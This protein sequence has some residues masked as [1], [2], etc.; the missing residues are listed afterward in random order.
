MLCTHSVCYKSPVELR[1][2]LRHDNNVLNRILGLRYYSLNK[3]GFTLIELMIVILLISVIAG[4]TIPQF[5]NFNHRGQV[6]AGTRTLVELL[7]TAQNLAEGNVQDTSSQ[8]DHYQFSLIHNPSDPANCY[9]GGV[10]TREDAAGVAV[11]PVQSQELL[12]CPMLIFSTWDEVSFQTVSGRVQG[13]TGAQSFRV[14]YPGSGYFTI[15]VDQPGKIEQ[16]E[17]INDPVGCSACTR[18]C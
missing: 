17:F 11:A 1:F 3:G 6:S 15:T 2:H 8:V 5:A 10:V 14:C 9:V 12:S 7:Q 13:I 18:A 4:A 16:S